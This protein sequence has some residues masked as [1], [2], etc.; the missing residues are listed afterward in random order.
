M[1]NLLRL[2][3]HLRILSHLSQHDLSLLVKSVSR[4][5]LSV[6]VCRIHSCNLKCT[7]LTSSK[8]LSIVSCNVRIKLYH[9]ANAACTV[10]VR[11]KNAFHSLESSDYHVLSDLDEQILK[12]LFNC[13][14]TTADLCCLKCVNISRVCLDYCISNCCNESLELIIVSS[15]VCFDVY[16][17]NAAYVALN[18]S[19]AD[20]L[21]CNS[22]ALLSLCS[23]S[24]FTEKCY[25]LF[26]IAVSFYKSLLAV[27]HANACC[28]HKFFDLCY[29][30]LTHYYSS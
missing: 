25:C 1:L 30:Y 4:N 26:H 27:H 16:F 14:V 12:C 6:Q 22:A 18:Y 11:N 8:E 20:T 19:C 2:V 21:C 23:K 24:L 13:L 7:V 28:C 17:K 15:K 9:N 5:S 10:N 3:S 29:G